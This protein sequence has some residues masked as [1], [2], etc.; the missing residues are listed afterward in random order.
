MEWGGPPSRDGPC[1]GRAAQGSSKRTSDDGRADR[2]LRAG[3]RRTASLTVT[4]VSGVE[5]YRE[6]GRAVARALRLS[7]DLRASGRP[8]LASAATAAVGRGDRLSAPAPAMVKSRAR[9][10][11]SVLFPKDPSHAPSRCP[12]PIDAIHDQSP[13]SPPASDI[14]HPHV[15]GA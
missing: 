9:G 7:A 4:E 11:R 1:P 14:A 2:R 12:G 8:T 13:R 15:P 6:D 3:A 10:R 5:H